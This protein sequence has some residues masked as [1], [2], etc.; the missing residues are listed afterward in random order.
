MSRRCKKNPIHP[1]TDLEKREKGLYHSNCDVCN[2]CPVE[3][4]AV[5]DE[6]KCERCH[7]RPHTHDGAGCD[8]M[9]WEICDEC[10]K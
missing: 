10:E 5:H 1:Y 4:H 2:R 9:V 7:K 8:D 6:D 3:D